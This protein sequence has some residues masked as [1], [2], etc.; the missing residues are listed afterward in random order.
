[1]GFLDNSTN[2]I[3]VD[4]VLTDY[5]R[6]LLARNDGS[7]SIVKFALGDDEVDYSTIK[8]FGRTVG[9]EKIEKNT[10]VFEAQTN[11]NFALKNKL[12][13]LSNPTLI[14]LP[15]VSITGDVS[16]GKMSFKRSGSTASQAITL[17][18]NV[19]D[20]NTIDPEL[21]DQA[22]I[23]KLPYRFVELDGSDNTPDSIDSDDIATYIVTRDSTT[24][25]IGG[26]QLSL[27]IKTRSISDS[28]FD[29]YGDADNK[30]QISSTIQVTGVQSG[31]VSELTIAIEK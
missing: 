9:K 30:S 1:M 14:K 5:G 18:Q 3:I 31:V 12:L 2:N 20:E 23:V 26:S 7:F 29:Y 10:P 22:F 11:Q 21:R 17:S 8:K 6:Q 25:S 19:S 13:S 15:G 27:T 28:V 4:A 24:T 16:S